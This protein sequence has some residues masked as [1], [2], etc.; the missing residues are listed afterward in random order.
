MTK[1]DLEGGSFRDPAG[2]VF[3]CDG[4]L[5]R[6]VNRAGADDYQA[7][8]ESGLYR[9][10][11]E[12]GLLVPHHDLGP[13][14]AAT[15]DAFTVLR[16]EPIWFISYPFEWCFGQLKAAALATLQIQRMALERGL[17]LKDASAYN[18]QF[19]RGRPVL[20]D[21][22]SFER[23]QE[24]R[25]WVAYRQFCQHFLAP[26]ALMS[27]T[28]VRLGQLAR[29]YVDGVPLD[30][31]SR[32][33]PWRT[34]FRFSWLTHIHLHARLQTRYGGRQVESRGR[35]VSR[36]AL[37]GI[38]ES[39]RAAIAGLKWLP[40]GTV[41]ADYYD[42]TNYS[43]E[44]FA[45]KQELVERF[46]QVLRPRTVWDLGSN[47]GVFSRVA[48]AQGA[49]TVAFDSDPA[50][51]ERAYRAGWDNPMGEILP[52]VMDLTNPT[53]GLGW[54][55]RERQS[56]LE[57]GPADACLALAL[58]HHLAIGNNVPLPQL[59]DF[60]ADAGRALVVE[61]V[62]KADSQ[63]QRMLATREDVFTEYTREA[64]EAAFARRF[65]IDAVEGIKGSHRI[66]YLMRRKEQ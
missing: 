47:E 34:R 51:V 46:L 39:L 54:H 24:G 61:F 58:V 55:H 36:A 19:R 40:E 10:L 12:A 52:L 1:A 25:P 38:L 20:I 27:L 59:A 13:D 26:L 17:S 60:F 2:F 15:A 4:I 63:V 48:A 42:E 22:L 64:F 62:P 50:A 8:M 45:H 57:R 6:Q 5:L 16:P 56:L 29:L 9:A 49:R 14:L 32:L 31:A 7:L 43:R 18:I 30:L 53:P 21:T 33:L 11:V 35:G 37:I 65:L 41:W 23:Y 3:W 44:G 66:L 28:D